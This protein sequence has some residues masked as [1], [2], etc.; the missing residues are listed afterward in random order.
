MHVAYYAR[1][2]T[3]QQHHDGTL[4]SQRRR[5]TYHMQQQHWG[6]PPEQEESDDGSSGARLERPALDRRRDAARRGA[7]DAGGLVSPD[8]LARNDAHQWLLIEE[9]TKLHT[10][11]IL[12]H[13]PF[14]ASPPGTRRTPRQGMSAQYERAQRAE[15]TR[16]G[17]LET[18]RRGAC[19]PWAS[20][21]YGYRYLP[22]RPGG[23]AQGMLEPAAADVVRAISRAVGEEP[24]SCRQL[25]TRLNAAPTAT[26][27][28]KHHVWH[29]A[30]GSNLLTNRVYAGQ[31]RYNDRQSVVPQYRKTADHQRRSLKTGRSSRPERAWIGRE[32]PALRTAELLDKAQQ[33]L[34][35]HG[36]TAR[37]MS[38]PTAGR[39]FLRPLGNCGACGLG[40]VGIRPLSPWKKY[41]DL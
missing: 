38:Q 7:C 13:K 25:T 10:P 9:C 19:M 18:A 6:L 36:A 37:K 14:G 34:Q 5:L 20:Q 31:V 32:A 30:P 1:V 35:R 11:G 4:E 2:S 21:C 39:Y 28:G 15:R 12:L 29:V 24:C 17:R 3:H 16:R 22:Q 23:T 41:A 40:M 26:P 27:T 33:H 8:R